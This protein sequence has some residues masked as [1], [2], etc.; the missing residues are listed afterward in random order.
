MA[1]ENKIVTFK[2]LERYHDVISQIIDD[3]Q[4]VISDLGTIR[5]ARCC[6]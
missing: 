3:K 1:N 6:Y 5:S 2:N 4:E